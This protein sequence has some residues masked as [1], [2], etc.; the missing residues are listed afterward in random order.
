MPV[1]RMLRAFTLL[2]TALL[3]LLVAGGCGLTSFAS[4]RSQPSAT[5]QPA[6]AD[7]ADDVASRVLAAISRI[8]P[9]VEEQARRAGEGETAA[10]PLSRSPHTA[11]M[12]PTF[13]ADLHDLAAWDH[14]TITA[15]L[16]PESLRVSGTQQVAIT[17]RTTRPLAL[18]A[19]H[20]YPNHPDF[21]GSLVVHDAVQVDGQPATTTL[22]QEG[23]L[24][25]VDLPH[26]LPPGEQAMVR[27]RFEAHT[28]RNA[29]GRSYGA[30]NQEA[31]VWALAS[32]Y[33]VL[34]YQF[35]N[36]TAAGA[37]NGA[38]WDTRPVNSQGDFTVTD[39]ALYDVTLEVPT[40]W[41]LVTT[42]TRTDALPAHD[43]DE[44]AA[45]LHRERFV[46]GPQRDFFI[47]ALNGLEQASM[48]VDG[49]H[50]TTYYRRDHAE[51]GQ[52]TLDV[53]AIALQGFNERYGVYPF[54]ELELIE[55]TL[56]SFLGVEYPGVVLIE[57]SLYE[58]NTRKLDTTVAHEVAHQWW[59]NLVG[60]D[61][62]GQAWL[63]EG[64]AS[65]S[66]IVYYEWQ[67][68]WA[69]AEQELETFRSQYRAGRAAGRDG[70]VNRPADAFHNNYFILT[71]AKSALFFHA[72]RT[73]MGDETFFDFVQHYY[74]TYRYR[75]ATGDEMIAAAEATCNCNLQPLYHDWIHSTTTVEIP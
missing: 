5:P 21:G 30:F 74:T 60:N 34:A 13:R 7:D 52:R 11:A 4:D 72:L 12:L 22:Q 45:R 49:T 24:L 20:L 57:Q 9:A 48:V 63:D 15:T 51:A 19:F 29:S 6:P 53:A 59:Y 40:G 26:P 32:F 70:I 41:V 44:P 36:G 65:Y 71:Y 67:G 38:G 27:L 37:G 46:S 2:S 16:D 64:L 50:I 33:P 61:A 10:A 73:H 68:A 56:T 69:D 39:T 55:T 1:L 47:A 17:N 18:L 66:Q 58:S 23:V 62:Q 25:Q 31:G 42:G 28:P 14:Y 75:E 54:N 3:V 8:V 35:A 43:M